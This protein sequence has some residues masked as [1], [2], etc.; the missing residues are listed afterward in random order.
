MPIHDKKE[1]VEKLNQAVTETR[2]ALADRK[3]GVEGEGE[4][5][6]LEVLLKYVE[7]IAGHVQSG[8]IPPQ[9]ER[10]AGSM[11]WVFTDGWDPQDPL[12]NLLFEVMSY[13]AYRDL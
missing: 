12:G 6:Q 9:R 7:T 4:E 13:Y 3:V 10:L 1:F 11:A 5:E 2:K 8:K